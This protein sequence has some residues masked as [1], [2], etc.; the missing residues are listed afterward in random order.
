MLKCLN[1]TGYNNYWRMVMQ[2]ILF[3]KIDSVYLQMSIHQDIDTYDFKFPVGTDSTNW[4]DFIDPL[5]TE[6]DY[7]QTTKND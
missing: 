3:H 7:C 6:D 5:D 1:D 2:M 4:W